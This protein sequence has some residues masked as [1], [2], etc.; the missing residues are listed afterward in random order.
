MSRIFATCF[1]YVSPFRRVSSKVNFGRVLLLPDGSPIIPVKSPIRKIISWHIPAA[2]IGTLAILSYI[3]YFSN[4]N[5]DP[6]RGVLFQILS[7]GV[8]LGAFFMAT[9]M[10]TSPI[11]GMGMLIFGVGCAVITFVIR[12]WGGY[13]E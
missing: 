12:I 11:T 2:F 9:D 7:G 5:I 4:G 1:R 6:F 10:V 13:P 8:I 3:Y